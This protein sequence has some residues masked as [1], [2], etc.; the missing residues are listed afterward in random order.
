VRSTQETKNSFRWQWKEE[1]KW[2]WL[3]LGGGGR[4]EEMGECGGFEFLTSNCGC[5]R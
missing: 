1:E 2:W 4:Y 5:D 3:R